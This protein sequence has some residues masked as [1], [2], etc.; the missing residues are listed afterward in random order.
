VRRIYVDHELLVVPAPGTADEAP[1]PPAPDAPDA[2]RHLAEAGHELVVV[3]PS[4]VDLG[5]GGP[6]VRWQATLGKGRLSGWYL[7]ADVHRC[8]TARQSGLR[9]VLVGPPV[10]STMSPERC[11]RE[12]RDLTT[13]ALEILATDVMGGTGSTTT[14][15]GEGG[16][17]RRPAGER[18]SDRIG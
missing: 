7:T 9:T 4:P 14:M 17:R 11:D 15:A 3:G 6:V 5:N 1:A 18:Q 16:A 12:A 10:P 8:S 13:A 2:L